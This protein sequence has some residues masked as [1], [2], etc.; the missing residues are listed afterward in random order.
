MHEPA[1]T[2]QC[3]S[4]QTSGTN[5]QLYF[6][7]EEMARLASGLQQGCRKQQAPGGIAILGQGSLNIGVITS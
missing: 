2:V 4:M 6:N 7:P 5:L 3:F 1:A